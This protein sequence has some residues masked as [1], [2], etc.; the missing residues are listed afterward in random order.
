LT[1]RV[2]SRAVVLTVALGVVAAGVAATGPA[3]AADTAPTASAAPRSAKAAPTAFKAGNYIVLMRGEPAAAYR[4]GE[5][6][7]TRTAPR[8]DGRYDDDSAAAR[9]YERL[10]VSRQDRAAS[11]VGA[12]PYYNY[13]A[14]LNG[15]AARLS[16]RQA[17]AL[18]KRGDVL[19]VVKDGVRQ[20]DTVHTPQML[21]L[22]GSVGLWRRLGGS[23]SDDG[24]GSNTIVG[25]I[26]TGINS[27]SASF[28]DVNSPVPDRWDGTCQQ[29]SANED[30]PGAQF[31]CNNKLIGGRYYTEGADSFA[32]IAEDDFRSPE[33][34][35]GHGSH[36]GSTAAGNSGVEMTVEGTEFGKGSGMAP[37]AKVAAYKV[38][39]EFEG[40]GAGCVN[41]DSVAAIDDAV[42][43]GV[44]VLNFS[45]S[46]SVDNPI[47]PVE[48]AFMYAA[49]AGVF[50]AASAGNSG[51]DASTV[52]H[53]S[54][55]LT[56]VAATTHITYE[57]TLVLGNGERYVGASST[58]GIDETPMVLARDAAAPET[59][60]E[61]AQQCLPDTLDPAEVDG[62]MVV[63]DRGI[64]ARV[65]KSKTVEDAGGVAMVLVNPTENS[66]NADV[67]FVPTVHL[68]N[69]YYDDIYSYVEEA[70]N[71]TGAILEGE[72]AGST[73]P[74]P[75]AIA[76]FSS[77]GPSLAAEGDLL[78]PD[79]S[80]PGVDILAAVAPENNYGR[81]FDLYSGTSM[82]S[83]HIAG[84]GALLTQAHRNWS[85]MEIKS[86]MMT[87]AK[88]LNDTHDP[89]DQGAGF[90][91]PRKF[92]NPGLVFNSDFD[93]WWNYL[94]GQG[95]TYTNGEPISETPIRAS[96]VNLASA[97]LNRMAG[98]EV[99]WRDVTNVDDEP[100]TYT[101][102]TT[103]LEGLEV[104]ANPSTFTI[105][106]GQTKSVRFKVV[107]T[108]A[109][110]DEY[111]K[112]FV[113]MRDGNRGGHIVRMPVVVRP[114]GIDA[115]PE[116][117]SGDSF[118][119]HTKSGINGVIGAFRRGLVA[120]ID[121]PAT[122]Q[123]S[124]GAGDPTFAGNYFD[125]LRVQG[126]RQLVRLQ[127]L[128][129]NPDDDLDLYLINPEFTE[130][131]AI[132]A[133]GTASEQITIEG[134]ER[135][136]YH[137]VVEAWLVEQG[138]T[139]EFTLRS[140]K[141]GPRARNNFA[142]TPQ[143][144]EASVGE[145]HTWTVTPEGLDPGT[146]YLGVITW[147]EVKEG[148]NPKLGETIIS[149]E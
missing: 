77:R 79:I 84:L 15:F 3:T 35:N 96:N 27:D 37:A 54:P 112:G 124:G 58:D 30:D 82:S 149:I 69:T 28:A 12:R 29:P 22:T 43:D 23:S 7:Y 145:R 42:K 99:F 106:P 71:P 85:P 72:N 123:D 143:R 46:G 65:E 21:G 48:L 107:R 24:A 139:A 52:A 81:D 115:P 87:T 125:R 66:L 121:T 141:V 133:T 80:A 49:D 103:G 57:S 100:S 101:V 88:N 63:C 8:G 9:R 13:T 38:C 116:T 26:D 83:P 5:A 108:T 56:T 64:I 147:R 32:T 17:S 138:D 76:A 128:P 39:W 97:A 60:P 117:G 6:G 25:I 34:F 68:Q 126:P 16:S 127:T 2:R 14:S 62:K 102:T 129:E 94:A 137:V 4:G 109:T 111:A 113:Y 131:V 70:E 10:L 104:T 105:K 92:L 148:P 118:T 91:Q 74:E 61:D 51:P 36:T 130:L 33:D 73:T 142:V 86:A 18:S 67:H 95:V 44:D 50:V 140:F 55:W 114:V 93:D 47:D 78:K 134:L 110:L 1:A 98:K 11:A 75:P 146:P 40:G 59:D 120:G 132:S 20:L 90:V 45:I 135:G 144:Q 122:A 119:I 89:F 19:A 53:P 41:S 136:N 31:D